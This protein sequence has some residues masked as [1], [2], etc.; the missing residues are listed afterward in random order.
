M[1]VLGFSLGICKRTR[2]LLGKGLGYYLES[3]LSRDFNVDG[4]FH[5]RHVLPFALYH[6]I[7]TAKSPIKI[8]PWALRHVS[9]LLCARRALAVRTFRIRALAG[10]EA[11]PRCPT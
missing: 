7:C 1:D 9:S 11:T 4:I 5:F 6:S 10:D 2:N 3:V 8:S